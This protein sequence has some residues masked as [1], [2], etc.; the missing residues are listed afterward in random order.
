[1]PTQ[2]D[3]INVCQ[4]HSG[5]CVPLPYNF[6]GEIMTVL[7]TW[8]QHVVNAMVHGQLG[9]LVL[10]KLFIVRMHVCSS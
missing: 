1:M 5:G 4:K 9:T 7:L 2:K 3:I 10:A 8:R 6:N